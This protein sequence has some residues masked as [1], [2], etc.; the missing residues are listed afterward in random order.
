M[1]GRCCGWGQEYCRVDI[2]TIFEDG[3]NVA[4]KEMEGEKIV[5]G[6]IQCGGCRG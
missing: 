6:G 3:V 2:G 1:V 5:G 4:E